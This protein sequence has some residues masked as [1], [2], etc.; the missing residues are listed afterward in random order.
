MQRCHESTRKH[1]EARAREERDGTNSGVPKKAKLGL[2]QL[3]FPE[4]AG[5]EGS[6]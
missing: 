2:M 6:E 1:N 5:R 4:L 3:A